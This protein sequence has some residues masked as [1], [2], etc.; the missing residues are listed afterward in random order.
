MNDN[1][2]EKRVLAVLKDTLKK[3]YTIEQL[4]T[5]GLASLE[6]NSMTFLMLVTNIENEF[7]IEFDDDEINYEMFGDFDKFCTLIEKRM[8]G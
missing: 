1:G 5:N 4:R 7:D 8:E 6:V 3:D 2:I